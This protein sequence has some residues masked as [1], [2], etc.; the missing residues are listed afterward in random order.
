MFSKFEGAKPVT[1]I[2]RDS[3]YLFYRN[4]ID[5]DDSFD[6]EEVPPFDVEEEDDVNMD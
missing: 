6:D 5:F 3:F 1:G 4:G 2:S